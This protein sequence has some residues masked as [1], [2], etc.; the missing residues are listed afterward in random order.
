[1]ADVGRRRGGFRLSSENF[2]LR[3]QRF[4]CTA[5]AGN[6]TATTD[7][8]DHSPGVR[9]ILQN[10]QAHCAMPGNEVVI[11]ERVTGVA[12]AVTSVATTEQLSALQ[13]ECRSGYVDPS[14]TQYAVRL[15]AATRNPE[16]SA[17]SM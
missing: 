9:H 10:F 3:F 7:G 13:R 5:Y 12:K 14:L 15:V 11:V 4:D 1:M 8:G 17:P 6:K 16:R 2:D